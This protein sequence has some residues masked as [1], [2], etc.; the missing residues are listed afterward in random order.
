MDPRIFIKN[1]LSRV[2]RRRRGIQI[3]KGVYVLLAFLTGS[4]LLGNLLSYYVPGLQ[5]FGIPFLILFFMALTG[6]LFYYFGRRGT[7]RFPID[8]AALL[9]EEKYPALNN[10]L[11][12]A[13]QFT[14]QLTQPEM[15]QRISLSMVQEQLRRTQAQIEEID[16]DSVVDPADVGKNR[17][18][19]LAAV[20]CMIAA[21]VL[22]PD[23][24]T[25]GY[26]NWTTAPSSPKEILSAR[27]AAPAGKPVPR[28]AD[29]SIKHLALAFHYPAYTGL[30]SETIDPS[31]GKIQALPGTE[32]QIRA[33]TNL[34]ITGGDLVLNRRDDFSMQIAED[35]TLATQFLL[36]E[37]G[38]YQIRVK[39]PDG[40]KY[41]LPKKYSISLNQDQSPSIILF[42]ANPKPVYYD[43][44]KV[45][46]FY[47]ANDDYG[48][49]QIDLVA[50]V[51]GKAMRR[52]VKTPR[53]REKDAKGSYSWHLDEMRLHPGDEVQY[54]LEVKDNDNVRGPNTGQSETF[55]FTIFDFKK[56][57]E[58][59]IQLQEQLTE[60]LI[61][62][63]SVSLVKGSELQGAPTDPMKW[64]N[65]LVASVD[66]LIDIIGRSQRILDRAKS[67]DFFPR[68]YS[69]LLKN[70]IFGLTRIREE[71]ID[72]INKIQ[73]RVHKSTPVSYSVL[74]LESLNG[75]LIA[76]LETD[77]LFLVKMTNRQ[78]MDQVMDLERELH[79]LTESLR[80]EFENIRDKKTKPRPA[81]LRAKIEQIRQTLQKIMDQLARQT[82]S[83]PDEFLNPGAF[84]R[85]D[86]EKFTASLDRIMDLVNRGKMEDAL[87]ELEKAAEDLRI[88][89]NQ[90]DQAR[91]N[92]DDMIDMQT[93]E[94]LDDSMERILKLEKQ[95]EK[96]LKQTTQIN[97]GLRELQSKQ[98][99]GALDSLF[100]ELRRDVQEIQ[101]ILGEDEKYLEEHPAMKTW[102]GLRDEETRMNQKIQEL[103]QKT[104]DSGLSPN[105]GK[106][107]KSLNASRKELSRILMEM[108]ALRVKI[109]QR[110]KEALPG[111]RE[112]YGTLEELTKL[113]DLNEFNSLFKNT[114]PEVFQWQNNLRTARNRRE[115]LGDR[116]DEDLRQVTRLNGEISKKL[117]S[118]M[119]MIQ[120]SEQS[121]LSEK[122]QSELNRMSQK[123]KEMRDEAD[124]LTR[125]FGK[126]NQQNP[127]ITP[128]LAA[129]MSRAGQHMKRAEGHLQEPNVHKSI[130]SENR[131]LK[132]LQETRDLLKEIKEA[133]SQM[134]SRATR[135]IPLKLG[136]GSSRDPRRGGSVRM[137][138]ERI[139]LPS[140]DQYRVPSEFR[141]EILDAMKKHTPKNY[142]RR[143]MEYYKEL[144]Q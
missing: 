106:N 94:Q 27:A 43:N 128:E 52:G 77:I 138:K 51:N 85:M 78:K 40:N 127:M 12:N 133:N 57:Q 84:K 69:N 25:R 92:L 67:L 65:Y 37:K 32:V 140:E 83:L 110:F 19:F 58:D 112:K 53:A 48:I 10:S 107:F 70:I 54:Y 47:E 9:T 8:R 124:R 45:E 104:V 88:L 20:V 116:M 66:S 93:M 115:D 7:L 49:K 119:R 101:S 1:F 99:E 79:D 73:S 62:Q 63:L 126:M 44:G 118:M 36:K 35:Q 102:D 4:V 82:Q 15:D 122:Q 130:Q 134:S 46:M 74:P 95:Q 86:L 2:R 108:D 131:A 33:Q 75:R 96:L 120:K 98:F 105:L 144:V 18:L 17:N 56:E 100:T 39:D 111:L 38:F 11:I 61:A 129:K 14:R 89:A 125:R 91:S 76:H 42:L 141:E 103:S 30:E 109:F 26:H 97:Q 5:N 136:T 23:L 22:V 3:V 59:L 113:F 50:F 64:K 29:Y 31:D 28:A 6:L 121:L 135:K 16:P 41:L 68:P 21:I 114:Y 139:R 34:P 137:Q 60:K 55:S 90:L 87:K 132:Q 143:V 142:E 81:E 123:E 13:C 24:L 117:G 72:M 71:Q 80:E